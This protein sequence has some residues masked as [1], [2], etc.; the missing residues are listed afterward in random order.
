[1]DSQCERDSFPKNTEAFNTR[2]VRD[3]RVAEQPVATAT[4]QMTVRVHL[5]SFKLLKTYNEGK[6]NGKLHTYR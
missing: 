4:H 6:K 5:T 2:S 1:M 3:V